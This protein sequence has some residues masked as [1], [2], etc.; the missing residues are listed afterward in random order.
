MERA[1]QGSSKG[2]FK[3]SFKKRFERFLPAF[4]EGL[5]RAGL[6]RFWVRVQGPGASFEGSVRVTIRQV[7]NKCLP[8]GP[9]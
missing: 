2:D 9:E 8:Y 4:F 3:V 1:V 5:F 7:L 6:G